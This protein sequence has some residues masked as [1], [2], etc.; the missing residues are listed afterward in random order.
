MSTGSKIPWMA[1]CQLTRPGQPAIGGDHPFSRVSHIPCDGLWFDE[2]AGRDHF[3]GPGPFS[4]Q[5]G[6]T[7]SEV[8]HR[9]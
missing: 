4:I 5:R 9:E 7:R 1:P 3:T 8:A 6:V 2:L